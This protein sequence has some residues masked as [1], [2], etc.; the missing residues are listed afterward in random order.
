[1]LCYTALHYIAGNVMKWVT[2][3]VFVSGRSQAVRIPKDFRF[4]TDE[5]Y[6]EQRGNQLVL[7]PKPRSWN[8]YFQ[9]ARR[10]ST[11]FPEAIEDLP[12]S[13]RE[14]LD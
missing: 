2:S 14:T 13:E 10:F 1:M 5:V 9:H 8:D 11:D 4:D 3:K 12:A 6:I 7:T